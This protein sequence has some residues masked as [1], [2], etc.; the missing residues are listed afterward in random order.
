MIH[1]EIDILENGGVL[2]MDNQE[3]EKDIITNTPLNPEFTIKNDP[4]NISGDSIDL[5]NSIEESNEFIA[6][7]EIDQQTNNG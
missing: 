4:K 7:K 5:H 3:R 1:I 6:E 2:K